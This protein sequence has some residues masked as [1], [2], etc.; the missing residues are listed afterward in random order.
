MSAHF[1]FRPHLTP[2]QLRTLTEYKYRGEDRSLTYKYIL[3]PLYTRLIHFLPLWLA[4]NAITF[5]GFLIVLAGHI[6]L[7]SY[8][9][10]FTTLAPSWAY[11]FA[12]LSLLIYMILDNLDGKQAR[13]TA[14]SSPLGHL[15][16]HA[17][18]ALNVTLSG[19]TM[20]ATIRLGPGRMST[21]LLFTLGQLCA[22]TANLEE[23][24]TG[25]MILREVNG[26][27]EGILC[28]SAFHL[29]TAALGPHIWTTAISLPVLGA[30]IP[31]NH[32]VYCFAAFP[33][34]NA[35]AG[36][37]IAVLR[38]LRAE[39]QG[40]L[41]ALGTL[42]CHSASIVVFG[43]CLNGWVWLAPIQFGRQ[44]VAV[45]WLSGLV[46][47]DLVSRLILATLAG[48]PFP[49][50]PWL[51]APMLVCAANAVLW[52]AF[53]LRVVRPEVLTLVTV[54]G[55]GGYCGW[56]VWCLVRQLC[57]Y[58]NVKCFTLG[59]LRESREAGRH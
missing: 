12:G 9:P 57:E 11:L 42:V 53:D 31:A 56:R 47:F 6:T 33:T 29:V 5:L 1:L 3:N 37:S 35:V 16:D 26:P 13:R 54:F 38:H 10:T 14:S 4:P 32:L 2:T 20:L 8:A 27:N 25:A 41:R 48:A 50:M 58:L 7:L 17:C 18:D 51:F 40:P 59:K 23:Y 24:F 44:V 49:F 21:S 39:R 28:L 34:L 30:P 15:F 19:M 22:F 43:L 52:E 46:L 36:N 45:L 55:V